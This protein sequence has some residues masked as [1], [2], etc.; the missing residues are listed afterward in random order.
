M[1]LV[2]Q[3]LCVFVHIFSRSLTIII[4]IVQRGELKGKFER[5]DDHPKTANKLVIRI[6]GRAYILEL[7]LTIDLLNNLQ[8]GSTRHD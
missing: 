2:L 5:N 7:G 3:H 6:W 1:R 8:S 4:S